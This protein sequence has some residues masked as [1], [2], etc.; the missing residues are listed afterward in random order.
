MTREISWASEESEAL[1]IAEIRRW[2]PIGWEHPDLDPDWSD[3]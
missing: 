1:G 3:V 2:L